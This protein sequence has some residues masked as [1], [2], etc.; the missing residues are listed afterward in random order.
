MSA[1][2][3]RV[4]FAGCPKEVVLRSLILN[5]L[6]RLQTGGGTPPARTLR[7]LWYQVLRPVLV[8]LE[9]DEA[10]VDP[11]A[12]DLLLTAELDALLEMDDIVLDG[13]AEVR[14]GYRALGIVD[15]SRHRVVAG[16]GP[17]T[18]GRPEIVL[19]IEKPSLWPVVE[20]L[21]RDLGVSALSGGGLPGY[22]AVE[23][24]VHGIVQNHGTG[25]PGVVILAAT[26]YDPEGWSALEVL[27]HQASILASRAGLGAVEARRVA[28]DPKQISD[29]EGVTYPLAESLDTRSRVVRWMQS[30]G[31]VDGR[32]VGIELDALPPDRLRQLFVAAID[33]L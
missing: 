32:F 16:G 8:R 14:V 3:L 10:A 22:A 18:T 33:D 4:Y 27:L 5:E 24:V 12:V 6:Q 23:E 30:T 19:F 2:E 26:D 9:H 28:V 31:G 20:T 1:A 25:A 7:G 17:G 21:A 29:L 15:G 11:E 13:V